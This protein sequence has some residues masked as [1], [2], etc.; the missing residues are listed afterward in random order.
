[1]FL[2]CTSIAA[3]SV[4]QI[5]P[6]PDALK[7]ALAAARPGDT[8]QLQNG[9]Y[10][11]PVIIEQSINLV[12]QSNTVIDGGNQGKVITVSAPDVVIRNIKIQH[13]GIDLSVEDSGIF[14]TEKGDRALIENNQL[15][16]NLIGIYL[17]G[18]DDVIVR[19]NMITGR[20]DLRMNE[21]GNGV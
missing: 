19:N 12:G 6:G 8:L 3:A 9:L 5:E 17:K 14:I 13:S 21:R 1:M 16:Q 18:P 10:S 20:N 4:V 11:G 2:Y 7:Q 15:Y